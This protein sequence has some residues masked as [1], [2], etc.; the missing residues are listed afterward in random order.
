MTSTYN[1]GKVS[2]RTA[3]H[4]AGGI[5]NATINMSK[6]T[7]KIGKT[8]IEFYRLFLCTV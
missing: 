2:F 6:T 8:P 7:K 4:E 3:R 5:S 1:K